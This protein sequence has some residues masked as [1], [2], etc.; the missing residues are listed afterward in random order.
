[1]TCLTHS[2]HKCF[3]LY[4]QSD[5]RTSLIGLYNSFR[6]I[7]HTTIGCGKQGFPSAQPYLSHTPV[8]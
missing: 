3:R 2:T 6:H 7:P 4:G 1:M 5:L 8:S